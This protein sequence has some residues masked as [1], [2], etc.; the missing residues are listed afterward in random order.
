MSSSEIGR[1]T[2][3]VDPLRTLER[4]GAYFDIDDGAHDASGK[5]ERQG[6]EVIPHFQLIFSAEN[7]PVGAEVLVRFK[8]T[9][10]EKVIPLQAA[11][12]LIS[13]SP[14]RMLQLSSEMISAAAAALPSLMEATRNKVFCVWINTPGSGVSRELITRLCDAARRNGIATSQLGLEILEGDRR[15]DADA[16]GEAVPHH[17]PFALDDLG[18]SEIVGGLEE[19]KKDGILSLHAQKSVEF[20]KVKVDRTLQQNRALYLTAIC[21]LLHLFPEVTVE[22]IEDQMQLEHLKQVAAASANIDPNDAISLDDEQLF[23]KVNAFLGKPLLV[24]GQEH[25]RRLSVQG[26][27][28]NNVPRP[29]GKLLQFLGT[30]H[31]A[32][33]SQ[34]PTT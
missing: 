26:Y 15:V 12:N 24:G 17:I 25:E 20:K 30:S 5:R 8:D 14:A 7:T 28:G 21:R 4:L 3:E 33:A 1:N 11:L 27:I 18:S 16:F 9:T 32:I 29:L 2:E 34:A 23:A 22:G 31:P 13:K 19:A 6:V 10:T